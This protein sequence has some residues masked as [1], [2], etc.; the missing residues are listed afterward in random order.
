MDCWSRCCKI[1]HNK[2]S[3]PVNRSSPQDYLLRGKKYETKKYIITSL[4]LAIFFTACKSTETYTNYINIKEQPSAIIHIID[5]SSDS[6]YKLSKVNNIKI[7]K[8]KTGSD[9]IKIP[10]GKAFTL[11][12]S[13]TSTSSNT[14]T[15][16][17]TSSFEKNDNTYSWTVN[18]P[19]TATTVTNTVQEINYDCSELKENQEYMF[20]IFSEGFRLE[21]SGT[22]TL[23]T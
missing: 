6:D 16:G 7:E 9:A 17:K 12:F 20:S 11:H 2:A 10:S 8:L 19:K 23:I 14:S 18:S 15:T 4:I 3:N 21:E 13:K 1:A 22:L 5:D